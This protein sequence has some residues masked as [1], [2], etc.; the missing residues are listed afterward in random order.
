MKFLILSLAL[1]C[2]YAVVT[3]AANLHDHSLDADWT[4]YK[5]AYDKQ[6]KD[7]DEISRR[8][9]WEQNLRFIAKHNKEFEEGK[10]SY[11]V[12][13]NK[14]GD[15]TAKEFGEI[16]TGFEME[17]NK[18]SKKNISIDEKLPRNIPDSIDWRSRGYIGFVRDQGPNCPGGGWAFSAAA[19]LEAVNFG[20]FGELKT[21]SEQN[22]IDCTYPYGN[23]GCKGGNVKSA[24]NM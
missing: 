9:I 2:S 15:L 5:L 14:F 23:N 16:Y 4:N 21:F 17:Q 6:Y 19:A 20:T 11:T 10:H 8:I 18:A 1:A 22:L 13:M 7:G 24:F 3:S 12:A